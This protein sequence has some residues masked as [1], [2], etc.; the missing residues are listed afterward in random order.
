MFKGCRRKKQTIFR[1]QTKNNLLDLICEIL[2]M[3]AFIDKRHKNCIKGLNGGAKFLLLEGYDSA[4]PITFGTSIIL[5][6][7]FVEF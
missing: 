5:S 7:Y 1:K 3:Q 4:A 6:V 2:K